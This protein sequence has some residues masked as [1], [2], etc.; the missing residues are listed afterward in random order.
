MGTSEAVG[1]S[2]LSF[3][4][5]GVCVGLLFAL[6]AGYLFNYYVI[7][8]LRIKNKNLCELIDAVGFGFQ[9]LI[10]EVHR[11]NNQG[12]SNYQNNQNNHYNQ[13]GPNNHPYT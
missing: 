12:G 10:E 6:L 9:H 11:Q 3:V 13:N 8:E 1:I 7:K 2:I 4:V 5:L